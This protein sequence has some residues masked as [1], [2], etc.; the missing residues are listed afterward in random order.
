MFDKRIIPYIIS[1]LTSI[2]VIAL[3]IVLLPSILI[4]VGILI[5]IA[6]VAAL[7][8]KFLINKEKLNGNFVYIKRKS[9][10]ETEQQKKAKEES[11]MKDVTNSSKSKNN[12]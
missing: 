1:A 2:F 4:L 8:I 10:N 11:K 5:L 9:Y 7:V 12:S 3:F 6:I